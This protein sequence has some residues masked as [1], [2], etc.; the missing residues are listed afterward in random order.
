[1]MMNAPYISI[2]LGDMSCELFV[3]CEHIPFAQSTD[4]VS[5][6]VCLIG[7][8][9][10]FNIAY[11]A[12]LKNV[13]VFVQHFILDIKNKQHVHVPNTA[14]QLCSTFFFCCCKITVSE[15]YFRTPNGMQ[16]IK[17]KVLKYTHE[18]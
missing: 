1:V 13:L 11:P 5:V 7:A 10:A 15:H 3:M 18:C 4:F 17:C 12:S 16:H 2:V 6:L 8:Y 14:L 9:F